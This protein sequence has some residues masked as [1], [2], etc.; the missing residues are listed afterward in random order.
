[1]SALSRCWRNEAV[2]HDAPLAIQRGFTFREVNSLVSQAGM[3]YAQV[4]KELGYR[5]SIAGERAFV[6][7]SALNP[8][9]RLA[10]I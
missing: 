4:N 9:I 2:T 1:M 5:F 3:G 6:L 7:S 10:G 8:A